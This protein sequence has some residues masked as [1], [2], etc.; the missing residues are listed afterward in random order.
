MDADLGL[1][2]ACVRHVQL[3]QAQRCARD[4]VFGR[5][6]RDV[7]AS[8]A[9][10]RGFERA[11]APIARHRPRSSSHRAAVW[12][13]ARR[14]T[15]GPGTEVRLRVRPHTFA[16]GSLV[17]LV[18]LVDDTPCSAPRRPIIGDAWMW[19]EAGPSTM[20]SPHPRRRPRVVSRCPARGGGQA[21]SNVSAEWPDAGAFSERQRLC[22]TLFPSRAG[23][24][25][26]C[27]DID[28]A[29]LVDAIIG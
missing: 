28:A 3:G 15:P 1:V 6:R 9:I 29:A 19:A 22:R 8:C 5:S 14:S 16:Q 4:V 7:R 10:G 24:V 11:C 2:S 26:T 20:R 21:S 12:L 18:F 27:E 17:S 25:S 23:P 13:G